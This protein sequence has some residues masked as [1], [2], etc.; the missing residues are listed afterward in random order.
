[1]HRSLLFDDLKQLHGAGLGA[2]AAG[3][4]LGSGFTKRHHLHGTDLDALA[5]GGAEL[6]VDH[7]YAGLGVL[8]DGVV[9]TGAGTLAALDAGF[10][11][12]IA[13]V[14]HDTDAALGF[15]KHLVKR[16][17]AG[18]DAGQTRH[19]FDALFYGKLFHGNTH[20]Q[21]I[22]QLHY[23]YLHGICKCAG[24]IFMRFSWEIGLLLSPP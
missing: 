11:L 8:G 17:G 15:I 2:D 16:L 4:A 23:T 24:D 7:V 20:L 5:A 13:L 19:A 9:G 14:V 3:D 12:D 18:P 1:M 22:L 6:L 10:D 21:F